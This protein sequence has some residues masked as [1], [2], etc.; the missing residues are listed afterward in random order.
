[1]ASGVVS[2]EEKLSPRTRSALGVIFV[3]LFIDLI[4][5]SIVFPLFPQMLTFYRDASGG[6][7]AFGL[8]YGWLNAL[9]SFAGS[10]EGE[11]GIIVLFGGLVGAIYSLLQFLFAPIIGRLS[12]R[13]GRRPVLICGLVGVLLS[14]VVWV[15]AGSFELLLLSRILGGM[16]SGNISTATAVVADVTTGR[17]RP[18]GMAIIGIAFGLGFLVGPALGGLLAGIDLT[19]HWPALAAWGVNP[20]SVPAA[21]AALLALFNVGQLVFRFKETLPE[22]APGTP[23]V[24]RTANPLALFRTQSHAGIGRTNLAYFLYLV[25]FSGMEFTLTFLATDRLGFTPRDNGLMFVFVGTISA[26]LQGGYVRRVSPRMGP[27]RMA[28]HGLA[29]SVPGMLLIGLGGAMPNGW[30]L[31]GGLALLAAG[32]AQTAPCLTALASVYG[33]P[34]E[35]G[36]ILGVFRSA[37]ALAR[38]VGPLAGSIAY[39]RLGGG[40]TYLLAGLFI[41]LPLL[42][43]MSLPKSTAHEETNLTIA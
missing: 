27:K 22:R 37:G 39:W 7:G 38:A 21:V 3:T 20:F 1:M 36:Q 18:K 33:P 26:V 34:E 9:T 35:Q 14:H 19:A 30:I 40:F 11:W 17:E 2:T 10:P 43:T 15:F 31:F 25:A 29:F 8:L 13:H 41:L 4:G 32:V 6:S 12:D 24:Q 23:H 5:F 28:V 42:I 16:M